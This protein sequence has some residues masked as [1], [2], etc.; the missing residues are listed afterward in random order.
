MNALCRDHRVCS[1]PSGASEVIKE[2]AG[3][4]S[5]LILHKGSHLWG[6][7]IDFMLKGCLKTKDEENG[8]TQ[9]HPDFNDG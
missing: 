9:K 8:Y 4:H 7:C 1:V 5:S 2:S 6:L 3:F